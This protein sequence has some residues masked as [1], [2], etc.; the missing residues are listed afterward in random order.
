MHK[1]NGVLKFVRCTCLV[2]IANAIAQAVDS[3]IIYILYIYVTLLV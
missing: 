1:V 2:C 3:Q